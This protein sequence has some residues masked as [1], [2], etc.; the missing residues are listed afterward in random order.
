MNAISLPV[1]KL[2]I[3]GALF[4]ACAAGIS[5]PAH[6]DRGRSW[7]GPRHG[8]HHDRG[9]H[10]RFDRHPRYGRFDGPRHHAPPRYRAHSH[11]AP[12]FGGSI[13]FRSAPAIV[14]PVL[15]PTRVYLPAPVPWFGVTEL[16]RAR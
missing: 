16:G 1:S 11:F 8:A 9:H 14:A 15:P 7:D 10:H 3:A 5:K 12:L 6:A 13:V 2:A 4:L